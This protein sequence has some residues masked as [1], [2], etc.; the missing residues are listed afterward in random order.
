MA[1]S[2]ERGAP[3]YFSKDH[4]EIVNAIIA[5]ASVPFLSKPT[6]IDGEHYLDGGCYVRI[7]YERAIERDFKKIIVVRTQD[8]FYRKKIKKPNKLIPLK[9]GKYPA[10]ARCLAQSDLRYNKLL[11][12]IDRD[13]AAGRTFVLAPNEP[14]TVSRFEK[15]VEKLGELYFKGYY[16]TLEKIPDLKKYLSA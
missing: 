15:D 6:E 7:G 12:Q 1:T 5:S 8:L 16:E 4:P 13:A 10:F 11:D 14:V 2:L 3:E 9:Y